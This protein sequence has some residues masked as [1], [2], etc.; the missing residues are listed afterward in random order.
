MEKMS[1][2][3][4]KRSSTPRSNAASTPFLPAVFTVIN[5]ISEKR[6]PSTRPFRFSATV[7]RAI[8]QKIKSVLS[9]FRFAP[10]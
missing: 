4:A 8:F 1:R 5:I 10:L 2:E 7:N 3:T 9:T 6:R